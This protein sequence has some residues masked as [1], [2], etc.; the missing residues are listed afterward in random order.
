MY[1]LTGI[2]LSGGNTQMF[3]CLF[4]TSSFDTEAGWQFSIFALDG[5]WESIYGFFTQI[6]GATTK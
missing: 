5:T 1:A 4:K 6:G 3:P 2:I